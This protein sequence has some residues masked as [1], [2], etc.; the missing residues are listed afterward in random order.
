MTKAQKENLK[1]WLDERKAIVDGFN[2]PADLHFY[3]GA[4]QALARAGINVIP[5]EKGGHKVF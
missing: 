4:L 2:N 3:N 1:E 5:D